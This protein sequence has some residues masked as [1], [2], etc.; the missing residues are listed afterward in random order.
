[1]IENP[2]GL[3]GNDVGTPN[4]SGCN[5][6]GGPTKAHLTSPHRYTKF[7]KALTA[8]Y[9]LLQRRLYPCCNP[10]ALC[11]AGLPLAR[12]SCQG[13][14]CKGSSQ[15]DRNSIRRI[16]I[17]AFLFLLQ[18]VVEFCSYFF[19]IY[20]LSPA[21]NAGTMEYDCIVTEVGWCGNDWRATMTKER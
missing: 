4:I 11:Q 2:G 21:G 7:H 3:L 16:S 12:P 6:A 8:A 9:E 17:V 1:M 5:D 19:G 18:V 14:W 20:L 13:G 15:E 10:R